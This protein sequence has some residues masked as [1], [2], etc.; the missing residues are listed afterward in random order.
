MNR[1]ME[2][3]EFQYSRLLTHQL[4][5]S[6][7]VKIIDFIAFTYLIIQTFWLCDWWSLVIN[8][9][10]TEVANRIFYEFASTR[11]KDFNIFW[12]GKMEIKR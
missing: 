6:L 8:A 10:I 3:D 11:Y 1:F 2:F 4:Q 9:M 12:A 7:T 5:F